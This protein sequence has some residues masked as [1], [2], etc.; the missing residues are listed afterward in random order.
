MNRPAPMSAT[1]SDGRPLTLCVI[2]NAKSVHVAT[3][4]R[5][6]AEMGHEVHLVTHERARAGV[7]GITQHVPGLEQTRVGILARRLL[8]P[9]LA[10]LRVPPHLLFRLVGLA[11]LLRRL[12]PDV[13]HVHYAHSEY[14]WCAGLLGCAPLV[15]SVMG[16]DVLFE[17]Q[18]RPTPTSRWLTLHLLDRA[19]RITAKSNYLAAALDRLGGFGRKTERIVWGVSTRRF[20]RTDPSRLKRRYGLAEGRRVI[21]SPRILQPLYQVHLLVEALPHVLREV[22]DATLLVTEYGA[23]PGYRAKLADRV[24]ELGLGGHVVFCGEVPHEDMAMLYSLAEVSVG[25]PASDGL[26][27]TLLEAMAC[28]TPSILSRLPRYEEVVR[29]EESAYFVD[30]HPEAIAG[31][32]LA[33]LRDPGL[34]E[35][36]SRNALEI[37]TREADLDDSARRVLARYRE[38]VATVPARAYSLSRFWS[39]WRTLRRLRSTL[40]A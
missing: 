30:T 17:E 7:E 21:L 36:I 12:R 6:F 23:D 38:L 39:A 14:G 33:L 31:G 4:A 16:G 26:P 34:R 1:S 24:A 3:R 15:V 22:P 25:I 10:A 5:C 11:W 9:V 40:A 20:R 27:Q 18:G 29:H 32:V 13:V 37:V 19:D 8:S 2:G 35:R 28:G